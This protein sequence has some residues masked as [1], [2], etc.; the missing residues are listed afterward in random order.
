MVLG[1]SNYAIKKDLDDNT[2]D[3]TSNLAAKS[4]FFIWSWET[5]HE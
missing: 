4:D 2:G 1:L 3:D 5:R